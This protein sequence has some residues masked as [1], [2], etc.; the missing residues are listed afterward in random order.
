[1]EWRLGIGRK[2]K[3]NHQ[4]GAF[5]AR[6]KTLSSRRYIARMRVFIF[7]HRSFDLLSI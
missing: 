5:L 2:I 6:Q 3:L 1:V 7:Y 4:P